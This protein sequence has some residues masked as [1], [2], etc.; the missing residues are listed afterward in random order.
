MKPCLRIMAALTCATLFNQVALGSVMSVQNLTANISGDARYPSLNNVGQVAWQTFLNGDDID[1]Y[2]DGTN[3]TPRTFNEFNGVPSLNDSGNLAW[4]RWYSAASPLSGTEQVLLDGVV[5]AGGN[6][7][8]AGSP[9]L[10]NVGQMAWAQHTTEWD[11]FL[12]GVNLTAALPGNAQLASLNDTGQ[13][14]WMQQYG[15]HSD[16]F[17]DGINLTPAN[18]GGAYSPSL[19]NL[20]QVAW[21]QWT[22][23]EFD[24]FLD[25]VNLTLGIQGDVQQASLNDLGQ[26]AWSD[27][28]GAST[29]IYLDGVNLTAGFPQNWGAFH[30][31]LNNLGQVAWDMEGNIYLASP[32]PEPP[33]LA[34]LGL[35]FLGLV[36]FRKMNTA[37]R[38]QLKSLKQLADMGK[39]HIAIAFIALVLSMALLPNVSLAEVYK[40]KDA[41]G[42]LTYSDSP[43]QKQADQLPVNQSIQFE[44]SASGKQAAAVNKSRANIRK[45]LESEQNEVDECSNAVNRLRDLPKGPSSSVAFARQKIVVDAACGANRLSNR[46]HNN[47][48]CGKASSKL[49]NMA[50]RSDSVIFAQQKMIVDAV[51]GTNRLGNGGQDDDA[52]RV[53][54]SPAPSQMRSGNSDFDVQVKAKRDYQK[55]QIPGFITHEPTG[56]HERGVYKQEMNRQKN[57]DPN[58]WNR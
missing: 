53:T 51:C 46:V 57:I 47:D 10:N 7:F 29:H 3:I 33:T 21:V 44:N 37:R 56:A 14:A 54:N 52:S 24:L 41:K 18:D 12:D 8:V 19:N 45:A 35:G 15:G 38:R 28:D 39:P 26:I 6:V 13:V 49:A 31:S 2:L 25:G 9:Q 42:K 23:T 40:C 43:C 5:V 11:I 22:G 20:G 1:L 32:V 50:G 55:Q 27:F 17:L 4:Q 48:E 16:I 34:L 30:P 58:T 36:S